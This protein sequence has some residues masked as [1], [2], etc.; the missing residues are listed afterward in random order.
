M[1]AN[2]QVVMCDIETDDSRLQ[3]IVFIPVL[4][5]HIG[6]Q[7]FN[8]FL[9]YGEIHREKKVNDKTAFRLRSVVDWYRMPSFGF[10]PFAKRINVFTTGVEMG[11][12]KRYYSRDVIRIGG[13]RVAVN[14]ILTPGEPGREQRTQFEEEVHEMVQRQNNYSFDDSKKLKF[15]E[16]NKVVN[17]PD[18][19]WAG[20]RTSSEYAQLLEEKKRR[21][22]LGRYQLPSVR[23]SVDCYG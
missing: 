9:R 18:D 13:E 21:R 17:T 22:E 20:L 3:V 1:H 10:N 14:P 16:K 4:C 7:G 12:A 11:D 2:F 6:T 8:I 23:E 19:D 15:V 5:G